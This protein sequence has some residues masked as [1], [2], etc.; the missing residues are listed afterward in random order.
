MGRVRKDA[1]GR[2]IVPGCRV[3]VPRR[4]GTG[5]MAGLRSHDKDGEPRGCIGPV[6]GRV[7]RVEGDVVTLREFETENWRDVPLGAVRVQQGKTAAE[8]R[9]R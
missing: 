1:Q 8:K 7:L 2:A 4:N 3:Y 5:S 9:R 6:R